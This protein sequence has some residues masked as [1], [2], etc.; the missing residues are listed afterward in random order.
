MSKLLKTEDFPVNVR[1]PFMIKVPLILT[2]ALSVFA[3]A[4]NP[5]HTRSKPSTALNELSQ[6]TF[7]VERASEST[8]PRSDQADWTFFNDQALEQALQQVWKKNLSIAQVLARLKAASAAQDGANASLFPSLDLSASKSKSESFM[9][10]R[11]FEQ[12]Q[13]TASV[14]ASYEIDL[15]DKLGGA[16]RAAAL[17]HEATRQDLESIRVTVSATYADLWF[18]HL[19]GLHE[20]VACR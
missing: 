9:F 10:G 17:E 18:Q 20:T 6:P 8:S 11:T 1:V 5:M 15:F 19:E 4:C 12:D 2:L 13:V 14:A 7:R 16:R 3:G